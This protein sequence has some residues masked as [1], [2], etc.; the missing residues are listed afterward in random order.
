MR[1]RM[2]RM[3]SAVTLAMV[4]ALSVAV[5]VAQ[6]PSGKKELPKS[7]TNTDEAIKE[8]ADAFKAAN[9]LKSYTVPKT[10]W[11][12]PDLRGVWNTATYTRLQRPEELGTKAFYTEEEAIAEYRRPLN[13]TRR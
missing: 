5:V 13:R 2:L 6:T 11:G 10:P 3:A 7:T 9:A 12:D 1:N 8:A 4:V